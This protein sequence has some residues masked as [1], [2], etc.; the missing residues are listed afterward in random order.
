MEP[1]R[2]SRLSSVAPVSQ[3]RDARLAL[4][5]MGIEHER[6]FVEFASSGARPALLGTDAEGELRELFF[7]MLQ[8]SSDSFIARAEVVVHPTDGILGYSVES[9]G[10]PG[11]VVWDMLVDVDRVSFQAEASLA[12]RVVS[13][14]EAADVVEIHRVLR[15]GMHRSKLVLAGLG[16]VLDAKGEQFRRQSRV[17]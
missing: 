4:V 2:D 9:A 17:R 5:T 12:E 16:F 10:G 6:G 1:K 15:P 14:A 11:I 13:R 3:V 8:V 7:S